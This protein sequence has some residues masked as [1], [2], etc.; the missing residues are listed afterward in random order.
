MAGRLIAV[1]CWQ[2]EYQGGMFPGYAWSRSYLEP[3]RI[4]SLEGQVLRSLYSKLGF[5]DKIEAVRS[6]LIRLHL[7]K[8]VSPKTAP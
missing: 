2:A 7:S 3:G 1:P 6:L 4:P 5:R 8:D